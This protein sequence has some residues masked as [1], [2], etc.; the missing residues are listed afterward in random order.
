M[1]FFNVGVINDGE[2]INY[3]GTC[4]T[5]LG[6]LKYKAKAIK[7]S[8]NEEIARVNKITL[9]KIR[10]GEIETRP[11]EQYYSPDEHF[12]KPFEF[13]NFRI[14]HNMIAKEI[15]ATGFIFNER[16][17]YQEVS[18]DDYWLIDHF[19]GWGSPNCKK[20]FEALDRVLGLGLPDFD[21]KL[22]NLNL[23]FEEGEFNGAIVVDDVV[24]SP[25]DSEETI[26]LIQYQCE[27]LAK[28]VEICDERGINYDTVW[29]ILFEHGDDSFE[30]EFEF[31]FYVSD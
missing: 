15:N 9:D 14:I 20:L 23:D 28:V 31:G 5:T 21:Y 22:E 10:S 4:R 17:H 30:F 29:E 27:C 12:D 7:D 2:M 1:E 6:E 26:K 19:L 16:G 24:F 11:Y 3:H 18:Y 13:I 8:A 25:K